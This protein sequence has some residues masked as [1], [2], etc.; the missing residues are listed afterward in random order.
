MHLSAIAEHIDVEIEREGEFTALGLIGRPV[1][2][3]LTFVEAPEYV[4]QLP[5][6]VGGVITTSELAGVVPIAAALA[7]STS[8]RRSFYVL[9][10]ALVASGYYG[11]REPTTVD[12]SATVHPTAHVDPI[13]VIIGPRTRV[14]AHAVVLAGSSLGADVVIGAGSVIGGGGFEFKR[15]DD[16]VM[17]V[18]HGGRVALGDRV[19]IHANCT[20]DR[21]LFGG[22]TKLGSDTKLDNLVHV[23]H[24]C[25]IG[26][27]CLLAASA[28]LAGSVLVGDDVW[29]GP[30]AAI[31]SQVAIGDG[32]SITI[33][34]VVTRDVEAGERVSGNFAIGHQRYLEFLRSIR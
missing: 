7:L 32:A 15:F 21:A 2:G 28:M 14:D 25:V 12:A 4:S 20:V 34:A 30:S 1:P 16:E 17:R 22:C 33:G 26:K 18:E 24:G 19:E 23:A 3:M 27:R 9:H 13:G 11:D 8:P 10:N 29:I 31:S 6:D 5:V